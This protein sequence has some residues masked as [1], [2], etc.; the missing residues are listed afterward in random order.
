MY[1]PVSPQHFASSLVKDCTSLSSFNL[2]SVIFPSV[3]PMYLSLLFQPSVSYLPL[4]VTYV[5]L[6][7][8][9]AFCQLSSPLCYLCTSLSSFSLLSVI[10]PSVLPMYLSLLFQPSVR[11][12]PLSVTYL[13]PPAFC[14]FFGHCQR[15]TYCTSLSP[16][17]LDPSVSCLPSVLPM[18]LSLLPPL[19]PA[20]CQFFA[21]CQ[22]LTYCTSLPPPSILSV[23][24]PLSKTPGG[25]SQM[26]CAT[27]QQR[28]HMPSTELPHVGIAMCRWMSHDLRSEPHCDWSEV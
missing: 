12:L 16:L 26:L 20:F 11:Y 7:P 4:C 2:L 5:P 17:S 9:S 18:C 19:P 14:Q 1:L 3:L 27:G 21:H 25:Q 8:L 24:L 10:F 15:L 6:S 23:L 22:R 13:L 28:P